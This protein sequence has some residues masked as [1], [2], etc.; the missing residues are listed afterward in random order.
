VTT[1]EDFH[2]HLTTYALRT[3]W[4][5]SFDYEL[6]KARGK[7]PF[8]VRNEFAWA[9]VIGGYRSFIIE[10]ADWLRMLHKK[11]L[12]KIIQASLA[13]MTISKR[14][15][16]R[17]HARM[18]ITGNQLD[19]ATIGS[20]RG[21]LE[22]QTVKEREG[23]MRRLF[24]EDAVK[25]KKVIEADIKPLCRKLRRRV[26][27]LRKLRNKLAHP[28]EDIKAKA[29]LLPHIAQRI[30]STQELLTDLGLLISDTSYGIPDTKPH[31]DRFCR[32]LVDL[33]LF[34]TIS[35]ATKRWEEAA[36]GKYDWQQREILYK[37]MRKAGKKTPTLPFNRFDP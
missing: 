20:I 9:S 33:I 24:G 5:R 3:A 27:E 32:D 31:E 22:K 6:T 1:L 13:K 25:R 2:N 11:G 8:A 30:G 35:F 28:F 4:M 29:I 10:F 7:L 18:P 23:A 14:H 36:P 26:R 19:A 12:K 16:A 17:L 34:G 21:H 15:A 37:R